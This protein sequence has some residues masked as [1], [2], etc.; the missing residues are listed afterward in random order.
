[1]QQVG[2][3]A[4]GRLA[5]FVFGNRDLVFLCKGDQLAAARQIPFAPGGDDFDVGV[6]RI[7]GQLEPHLVIAFAGGTMRHCIGTGLRR[8]FHQPL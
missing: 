6:Q 3:H 5:A 8:N 7:G 1:M 4:K 2:I